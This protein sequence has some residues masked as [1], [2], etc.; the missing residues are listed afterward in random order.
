MTS[1]YFSY[2]NNFS[3]LVDPIHEN[4][5]DVWQLKNYNRETWCWNDN[6]FTHDELKK[7]IKIGNRFGLSKSTI[8]SNEDPGEYRKSKVSW[9][10][11]NSLTSWIYERLTKCIIQ[12]NDKFF[13]YDISHI[14][15]IQFTYY[16]SNNEGC[17]K[18]HIDP[19]NN[20]SVFNRKLSMVLQL[21]SPDEYEGGE[22]RLHTSEDPVLIK[23]QKGYLVTFPSHTLHEVTPVTKGERYSLVAWVHGKLLR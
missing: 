3:D 10:T 17:Y 22:L 16:N 5:G 1:N 11:P 4:W 8:R 14:E 6:I 18:K 15:K 20:N 12:N 13:Q 2:H 19:L 9:L 21:S 7:I 23:K